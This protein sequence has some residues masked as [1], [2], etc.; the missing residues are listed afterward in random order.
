MN[1]LVWNELRA[2]ELKKAITA[3]FGIERRS[4]FEPSTNEFC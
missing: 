4:K 2:W 3:L 1:V